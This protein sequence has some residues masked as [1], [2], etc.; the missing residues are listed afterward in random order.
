MNRKFLLPSLC[1]LISGISLLTMQGKAL[2]LDDDGTG[3]QTGMPIHFEAEKPGFITLVAEDKDGNRVKNLVFDYPVKA[4]DNVIYWDGS[5]M[6][7][8]AAPGTYMVRGIFHE[9]ITPHLEYSIYSS[10]RPPWPTAE[11]PSQMNWVRRFSPRPRW[12]SPATGWSFCG[13]LPNAKVPRRLLRADETGETAAVVEAWCAR[14]GRR[15][16]CHPSR[17]SRAGEGL[18]SSRLHK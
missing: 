9:G 14:T 13:R 10:G 17:K 16:T 5:S 4:G 15:S 12:A 18:R 11:W 3:Q 1:S 7:G 2:A 6:T 8:I